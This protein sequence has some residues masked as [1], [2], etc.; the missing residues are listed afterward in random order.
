MFRSSWS[1]TARTL[2]ETL[3]DGDRVLVRANDRTPGLG[4]R[5]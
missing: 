4:G 2:I 3:A 5:A 1:S